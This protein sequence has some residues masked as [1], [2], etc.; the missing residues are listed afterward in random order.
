[1]RSH[2]VL[3]WGNTDAWVASRCTCSEYVNSLGKALR[4]RREHVTA[5]K[6]DQVNCTYALLVNNTSLAAPPISKTEKRAG[7]A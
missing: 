4:R 6:K 7:A 2:S 1:M 3:V 5:L